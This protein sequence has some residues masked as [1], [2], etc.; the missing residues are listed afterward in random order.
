MNSPKKLVGRSDAMLIVSYYLSRCGVQASGAPTAPPA[1]LNVDTWRAAY[2]VFYHALSDGR[3]PSQFRHSLKNARDSYDVLFDN[4]RIGW[5][6]RYGRRAALTQRFIQV[7]VKWK[8]EPNAELESYVLDTREA[9]LREAAIDPEV[10]EAKTEGGAKVYR[11]V[12]PERDP[13]LRRRAL[14]FHGFDCMAC[15]FNFEKSYGS[16][17]QHF[18]EV[19]HVV[20]LAKAGKRETDPKTDLVV[21]CANCHRMVHRTRGI[22]LSLEEIRKYV[23][24]SDC[25]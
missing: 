21:L 3:T 7:H 4:G 9:M 25:P 19:H 20:P 22:C 17:G 15:G 14:E 12:K 2:D 8:S 13:T 10:G 11:S 16:V 18:I 23:R 24:L 5:V 1:A 6:D